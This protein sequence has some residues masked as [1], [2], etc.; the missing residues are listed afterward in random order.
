ME[1]TTNVIETEGAVREKEQIEVDLA[2]GNEAETDIVALRKIESIL[3][4]QITK[5]VEIGAHREVGGV[6]DQLLIDV[7]DQEAMQNQVYQ[8]SN[9]SF[10][11]WQKIKPKLSQN[12]D[13]A[14][15][16]HV[17]SRH[18][19]HAK[20]VLVAKAFHHH[21]EAQKLRPFNGRARLQLK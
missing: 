19:R 16:R 6:T 7:Q 9:Q 8:S 15:S 20:V 5:L 10:W 17:Q 18:Q 21:H 1:N 13:H 12:L 3:S 2:I 4:K 11:T 14:A